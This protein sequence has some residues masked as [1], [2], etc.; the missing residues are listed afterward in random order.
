M[1]KHLKVL[2][3][4]AMILFMGLIGCSKN[5]T[6]EVSPDANNTLPSQE[7][8]STITLTD[9]VGREVELPYPVE[10]AV[11]TNRYN[12]ELIRACGAIDKVIATDMN[13][14]QDREYWAI[15]DPNNVIGTGQGSLNYEKIIELNPQVLLIPSNG[16]WEEAE[17]KLSPFD[18]KVFVLSGYDTADFENQVK[19]IGKMFG[20]EEQAKEFSDYFTGIKDYIK[21]NVKDADKK[22]IYLETVKPL[23][24]VLPGGYYHNMI[25][26]AGGKSIFETDFENVNDSEVDPEIVIDR[27][28]DVIVKFLTASSAMKG[29]GLYEPPTK[30]EYIK[31]YNDI[32]GR[33]GWD[34]ITAVKN[35]DIYFMTQFSHGGASKL[36]GMSYIADCMYPDLLS[37]LDSKEVFRKWLEDFQ[38]FKNIEG[39]FYSAEELKQ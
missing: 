17:E 22:T 18:I 33:P 3:V 27:N 1:K 31:V 34:S 6:G 37:E 39:H 9:N 4:I 20:V 19:N 13:T 35:D 25:V 38:G 29:T 10:K 14:A 15:F 23:T 26:F 7:E 11:V 12:S 36:V 30:E 2:T 32:I 24:T 28:P 5:Q 16:S 8:K 21:A